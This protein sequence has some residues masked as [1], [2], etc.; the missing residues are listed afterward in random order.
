MNKK[1]PAVLCLLLADRLPSFRR[2]RRRPPAETLAPGAARRPP[3]KRRISSCFW[4]MPA[5]SRLS[6]PPACSVMASRKS[7][8]S[9]NG[10]TSGLSETSPVDQFVSGFGQRHVVD[11]DRR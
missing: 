2:Q 10:R 5:A 1:K 4:P 7:C 8:A 6:M 11:H 3:A 9:S